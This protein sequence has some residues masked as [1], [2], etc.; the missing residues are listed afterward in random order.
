MSTTVKGSDNV[1]QASGTTST[2]TAATMLARKLPSTGKR[3]EVTRLNLREFLR[4]Y[5]LEMR[6]AGASDAM[7]WSHVGEYCKS[8]TGRKQ[9]VNLPESRSREEEIGKR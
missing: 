9:I 1:Q 3:L 8:T 5:K 6:D 2:T 4:R 7:T